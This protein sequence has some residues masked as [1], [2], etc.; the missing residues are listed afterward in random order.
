MSA[1]TDPTPSMESMQEV[2]RAGGMKLQQ[3]YLDPKLG[4]VIDL[5]NGQPRFSYAYLDGDTITAFAV[6]IVVDQIDGAPVFHAGLAV[7]PAYRRQ[8]RAKA[9][10]KAAI[11]EMAAGFGRAG[12]PPFHVEAVVSV[13]NEASN[14]VC[15]SVLSD[16]PGA[17]KDNVSGEPALH[18]IRKVET[19]RP[20]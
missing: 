1:M 10:L 5:A 20:K 16:T 17:I 13:D 6:M 7:P 9:I 15:R 4:A 3:G 14:A 19:V 18:S 8:G 11:A 2:L 12:K